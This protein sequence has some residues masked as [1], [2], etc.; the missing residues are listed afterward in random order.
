MYRF[1]YG[2]SSVFLGNAPPLNRVIQDDRGKSLSRQFNN[3]VKRLGK[4]KGLMF[5][6]KPHFHLTWTGGFGRNPPLFFTGRDGMMT[7]DT[8]GSIDERQ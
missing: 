5:L 6:S 7:Y 4:Q 2:V 8:G 3:E 1:S